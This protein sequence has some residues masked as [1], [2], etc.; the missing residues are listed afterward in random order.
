MSPHH[1][2][3]F[4]R[5]GVDE[6]GNAIFEQDKHWMFD[7]SSELYA[8]FPEA[9][10]LEKRDYEEYIQTGSSYLWHLSDDFDGNGKRDRCLLTLHQQG[11]ISLVAIHGNVR[12]LEFHVLS[13]NIENA[14]ARFAIRIVPRGPV[15]LSLA[16]EENPTMKDL[17]QPGIHLYD[18]ES[19]NELLFY[20]E[21]GQ[22]KSA[23][24]GL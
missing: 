24:V 4:V 13:E 5:V 8:H 16:D 2:P 10:P 18:L 14:P 7:I 22:Y 9:R 20:W 21:D 11:Y 19:D 23:Y 17:K 6:E 3:N 15:S 12:S 1:S